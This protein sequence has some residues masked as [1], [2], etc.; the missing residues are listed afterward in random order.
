[1][2]HQFYTLL[3]PLVQ[4][5]RRIG[6]EICKSVAEDVYIGQAVLIDTDSS[7]FVPTQGDISIANALKPASGRFFPSIKAICTLTAFNPSDSPPF[8]TLETSFP[9]GKIMA[10]G[11]PRKLLLV[12]YFF[13]MLYPI[14]SIYYFILLITNV[15][16]F[17]PSFL[18]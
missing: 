11:T 2:L 12:Y 16:S 4:G 7:G 13:S 1:M 3:V 9:E 17:L 18:L 15:L 10:M 14:V 5:V 8:C 6:N